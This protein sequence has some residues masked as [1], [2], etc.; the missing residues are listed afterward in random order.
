MQDER[1]ITYRDAFLAAGPGNNA[2]RLS[3]TADNRPGNYPTDNTNRDNE[4]EAWRRLGFNPTDARAAYEIGW[5]AADDANSPGGALTHDDIQN[6]DYADAARSGRA[7]FGGGDY[8][9][10]VINM[11]KETAQNW[12]LFFNDNNEPGE[13]DNVAKKQAWLD[14]GLDPTPNG[15]LPLPQTSEPQ[16]A[17]NN[18]WKAGDDTGIVRF[19]GGTVDYKSNSQS[20]INNLDPTVINKTHLDEANQILTDIANTYDRATIA[21]RG[22]GSIWQRIRDLSLHDGELPTGLTPG[23]QSNE[24]ENARQTRENNLT[25]RNDKDNSTPDYTNA[26]QRI[27]DEMQKSPPVSDSELNTELNQNNW[28]SWLQTAQT[29]TELNTLESQAIN[30]VKEARRKK[31]DRQPPRE[32]ELDRLRREA[33]EAVKSHWNSKANSNS[34]V[35]D[36]DQNTVLGSDWEGNIRSQDSETAINAK[37]DYLKGLIDTEKSKEGSAP[38][39]P[40]PIYPDGNN[41]DSGGGDVGSGENES[42][43]SESEKP[44]GKIPPENERPKEIIEAIKEAQ[45]KNSNGDKWTL[46]DKQVKP[47]FESSQIDSVS[48]VQEILTKVEQAFNAQKWD[49]EKEQLSIYLREHKSANS[50]S[51]ESANKFNQQVDRAIEHLQMLKNNQQMVHPS[52]E[53]EKKWLP[54]AIVIG[55]VGAI[56]IICLAAWRNLP[57]MR[58]NSSPSKK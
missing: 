4:I 23:R 52:P 31:D 27:K 47:V 58:E 11:S 41:E 43:G 53:D 37:R 55:S 46:P 40:G 2:G 48:K 3:A 35:N 28:E 54:W 9:F 16:D 56:S 39:G 17:W 12:N 26:I 15:L 51:Y 50:F 24:L 29:Q 25:D 6:K 36:K 45:E 13:I 38:P 42:N 18:G 19:S 5:T 21:N 14:S 49:K 32:N 44:G 22:A 8:I 1:G 10:N 34:K 20:V 7:R 30:A 57:R 33:I